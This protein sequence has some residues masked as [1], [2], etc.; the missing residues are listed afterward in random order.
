[1][2]KRIARALSRHPGRDP[3]FTFLADVLAFLHRHGRAL[4]RSMTR[5]LASNPPPS[6]F[7]NRHFDPEK[8]DLSATLN[9]LNL[10][11]VGASR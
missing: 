5:R 10:F 2:K 6:A 1:M 3:G 4:F 11:P 9:F 7:A 8:A